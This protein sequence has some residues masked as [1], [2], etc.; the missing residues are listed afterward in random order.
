[1]IVIDAS[2]LLEILKRTE[3]GIDFSIRLED[4]E[5]HAPHLIDLEV[6]Q[7]L[8]RLVIQKQITPADADIAVEGLIE[9]PIQR[10]AHIHLLPH[11]WA[12]R[13]NVSVY[14]ACYLALAGFLGAELLTADEGLRQAAARR[15]H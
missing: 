8:R 9:L 2:A 4:E 3:R 12:L 15:G 10:H 1:M 7:V 6:T 5:L 13:H 14:D 11:I